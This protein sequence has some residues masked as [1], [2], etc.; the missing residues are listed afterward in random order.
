MLRGKS[1]E[2]G[3]QSICVAAQA[4]GLQGGGGSAS[5]WE[6]KE[7]QVDSSQFA[8]Q[9]VGQGCCPTENQEELQ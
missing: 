9:S 8:V 7:D 6:R 2:A 3:Q 4:R 1:Q 5:A